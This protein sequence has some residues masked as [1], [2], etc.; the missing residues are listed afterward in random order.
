MKTLILGWLLAVMTVPGV[1]ALT[2]GNVWWAVADGIAA[3][4]TAGIITARPS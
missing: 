4:L 2:H 3:G 1:V